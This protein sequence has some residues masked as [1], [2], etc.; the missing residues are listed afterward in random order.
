MTWREITTSSTGARY[1]LEAPQQT[2]PTEHGDGEI[3]V[4]VERL[5]QLGHCRCNHRKIGNQFPVV[6]LAGCRIALTGKRADKY[7]IFSKRNFRED[8]ATE[9]EAN[10]KHGDGTEESNT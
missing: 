7:R 9:G 3:V 4:D 6:P 1:P 10:G 5:V 8:D 2:Q